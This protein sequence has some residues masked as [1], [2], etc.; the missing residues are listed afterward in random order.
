MRSTDVKIGVEYAATIGRQRQSVYGELEKVRILDTGNHRYDRIADK[1]LPA[2]SVKGQP[3]MLAEMVDGDSIRPP[4]RQVLVYPGG[5]ADL[6]SIY[7]VHRDEQREADR[8]RAADKRAQRVAADA[9]ATRANDLLPAGI[10]RVRSDFSGRIFLDPDAL[11]YL[12][13]LAEKGTAL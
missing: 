8:K 9:L 7:E 13:A 4:G 2:S 1:Y 12:V 10:S 11:A 6:W 5:I 3:A